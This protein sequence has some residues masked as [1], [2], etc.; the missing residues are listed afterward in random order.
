[1]SKA[2]KKRA[3]PALGHE[4]SSADCG[5]S[6]ISRYACP[7]SCPHLPFAPANY[8][9]V[10]EMEDE[11]DPRCMDY[12]IKH[13]E[14]PVTMERLRQ[15]ALHHANPHAQ[16]AFYEWNLFFARDAAGHTCAES[17]EQSADLRNDERVLLRAKMQTR[18]ALLEIHRVLDHERIDGADLLAPGEAPLRLHDRNLASM[19]VRFATAL[20]WV[21]PLPHYWRLSGTAILIPDIGS[22]APREIVTEIVSHLGGPVR[23]AEMRH[24]LAEN[25]VQVDEALLATTQTRR[26]QMFAGIDAKFGKA[27][28]ELRARFNQCRDLLDGQGC[29]EPDRLTEPERSE[30]FAEARVWFAKSPEIAQSVPPGGQPVLGRVLLGQAHWRLE[31][32]GAGRLAQLRREFETLFGERAAFSGERLDDL[33]A[34]LGLKDPKVD[35]SLAPPRLLEN[36]Q[37]F[38]LTTSRVD[39]APP[40]V[41]KQ[42][43]GAEYFR[44]ADRQFLDDHIPALENRT[45]RE[46]SRD[47][48][49]RPRLIHLLKQRVR[50]QDERNLATGRTDDVNWLLRE[51]GA[52][53]IIFDP[54]PWRPPRDNDRRQEPDPVDELLP[55]DSDL[56]PAPR[57][58][59]APFSLEEA[60]RRMRA[61]MDAFDTAADALD[62][63][64]SGGSEILDQTGELTQG[65][66]DDNG[67]SFAIPF[68]LQAILAMV[69]PGF[70]VPR[71][72]YESLEERFN[73]NLK[74]FLNALEAIT[75]KALMAYLERSSQPCLLQLLAGQIMEVFMAA[76]KGARLDLKNQPVIIALVKSVLEELDFVLRN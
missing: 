50:G 7:A 60:D 63:I 10:L 68:V 52:D 9:Q 67:Y 73:L 54:P 69:P 37:Q 13:A 39:A 48:A 8:S 16:N 14:D 71:T 3:C 35:K 46:A 53:E 23:E 74:E 65:L 26:M 41:S 5:A 49:L 12:M 21:F 43:T 76:P 29:V 55:D 11:L 28:Y 20:V 19:A 34:T 62:A 4:I 75:P 33:N 32:L 42:Q 47:A 66:L 25:F 2:S 61:G 1:M 30:G 64:G 15:K 18:V 70:R 22:F 58:P 31:A 44:A 59:A 57:L 40:G 6:R 36:P 24:W 45:P 72:S 56:P 27:I 17:L 51:L 38:V